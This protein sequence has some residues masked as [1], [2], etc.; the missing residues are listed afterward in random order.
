[1]KWG[2]LG[3]RPAWPLN[4]PPNCR[5]AG[6]EIEKGVEIDDDDDDDDAIFQWSFTFMSRRKDREQ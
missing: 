1:M 3:L 4:E 5:L 6:H 2:V